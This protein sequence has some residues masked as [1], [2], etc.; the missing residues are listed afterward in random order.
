[1][2][3]RG[4]DF[5][6]LGLGE[7][8]L[9]SEQADAAD[10]RRAA[11]L[12]DG[13]PQCAR[14][15]RFARGKIRPLAERA[16][17]FRDRGPRAVFAAHLQR[18]AV[19][20]AAPP[21]FDA[22]EWIRARQCDLDLARAWLRTFVLQRALHRAACTEQRCRI[23]VVC[24][25]A[26]AR[27]V[28][29]GDRF[30]IRRS[31]RPVRRL[32]HRREPHLARVARREHDV[33]G[34]AARIG[35]VYAT[36]RAGRR[37]RSGWSSSPRSRYPVDRRAA[38]IRRA[39]EVDLQPVSALNAP[40]QRSEVAVDCVGGAS[41]ATC[42]RMRWRAIPC[43]RKRWPDPG[44]FRRPAAMAMRLER[45][46]ATSRDGMPGAVTTSDLVVPAAWDVRARCGMRRG[47]MTV[48]CPGAR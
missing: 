24:E 29:C 48:S 9:R 25:S 46:R 8:L 47:P 20:R 7:H 42:S 45:C 44:C 39:S 5:V 14:R 12:A 35:L 1:M 40:P 27:G 41:A 31:T 3:A 16:G 33:V 4:D 22:C 17:I 28:A 43:A 21:H 18:G 36:S 6:A 13:E 11:V 15:L 26:D 38:N 19:A 37:A 2:R 32:R 23:D 10:D 30:R 34:V